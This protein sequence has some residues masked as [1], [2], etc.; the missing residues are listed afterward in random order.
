MKKF[1][2]TDVIV[3]IKAAQN[4]EQALKEAQALT[5]EDFNQDDLIVN[6]FFKAFPDGFSSANFSNNVR[7]SEVLN[8]LINIKKQIC[9]KG[10]RKAHNYL[11]NLR[12]SSN[13]AVVIENNLNDDASQSNLDL[14]LKA[15]SLVNFLSKYI[16]GE[17]NRQV[18]ASACDEI[19]LA[20]FDKASEEISLVF[21]RTNPEENIKTAFVTVK[22]QIGEGYQ[23]CPKAIYQSG[24][25]IPMAISNC[26]E[27]CIDARLHPDGTVGCN[28]LKWLN[29]HLITQEQAL[30][31]FDKLD[32]N[33]D[34]IDFMNLEKGQRT[35]FP[36]SDQDSQD[37]RMVRDE[38][39]TQ[40][41]TM[42]PWEEQL[43]NSHKTETKETKTTK[44][45]TKK[46][47][48]DLALEE[49]LKNMRD[50][51]DEDELDTLEEQIRAAVE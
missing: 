47:D 9:D 51:F 8:S 30:N 50:V 4:N 36:M 33:K 40:D 21:A 32:Y 48:S 12:D 10:L 3:L 6:Y 31:L 15:A 46:E 16:S 28:Y 49:L 11:Q 34:G 2:G 44:S 20:N 25:P 1:A 35:H 39:L 18:L 19:N 23:L 26:R 43:S 38:K 5:S 7:T 27:Y 37:L 41:V 29:E 22:Q 17:Q 24:K 45:T 42:K 14:Q 13:A